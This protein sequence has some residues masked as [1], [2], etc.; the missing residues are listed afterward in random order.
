MGKGARGVELLVLLHA[1]LVIA[2]AGSDRHATI[3]VHSK[4]LARKVQNKRKHLQLRAVPATH[5]VARIGSHGRF[6]RWRSDSNTQ[7]RELLR[8]HALDNGLHSILPSITSLHITSQPRVHLG[9]EPDLSKGNADIVVNDQELIHQIL[10]PRILQFEVLILCVK[11]HRLPAVVHKRRRQ[12]HCQ[13]DVGERNALHPRLFHR[14]IRYS[15]D[16][17]QSQFRLLTNSQR[18]NTWFPYSFSRLLELHS[19]PSWKHT[20]KQ[21]ACTQ[22]IPH[23]GGSGETRVQYCPG[24]RSDVARQAERPASHSS[25]QMTNSESSNWIVGVNNKEENGK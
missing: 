24:P 11:D 1:V 4:S 2:T 21:T 7:T 18:E 19:Y 22:Q 3:E 20:P 5:H 8:V 13:L 16:Q 12:C 17:V 15:V 14:T 9:T 6:T 10:G 25:Q 23:C